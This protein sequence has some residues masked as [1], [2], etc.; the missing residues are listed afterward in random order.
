MDETSKQRLALLIRNARGDESQRA[1]AKQIGVSY[2]SL[3][4]WEAANSVPDFEN[5]IAIAEFLGIQTSELVRHILA[6]ASEMETKIPK[7]AAELLPLI[8]MLTPRERIKL[9]NYSCETLIS[10]D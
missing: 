4:A 2:S 1:F 6:E 5:L 8:E 7:D 9:I 10:S 3:Q